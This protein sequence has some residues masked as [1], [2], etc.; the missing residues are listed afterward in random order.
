MRAFPVI[1]P[2][3]SILE[4]VGQQLVGLNKKKQK[5]QKQT[6]TLT[7]LREVLLPQL[8]SGKLKLSEAQINQMKG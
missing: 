6:E 4:K 5:N 7:R 8:I 3:H 1:I 2:F